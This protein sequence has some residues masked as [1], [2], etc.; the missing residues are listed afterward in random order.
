MKKTIL[1]VLSASVFAVLAAWAVSPQK[2]VFRGYDD[3]LRGKFDGVSL[4][5][6]AVLALAPR[7]DKIDGP[8]EDFYLSFLPASDGAAYLGTGH[9]GRIYR[10]SKEGKSE[11]FAQLPEMDVTCLALDA[12]GVLYAGTSPNGKVYKIT[13][14]G[15]AEVFFD[16]SERYIWSLAFAPDNGHL[17]A[18][19]GESGGIYEI[20]PEGEGRMIFKAPENHILC[21][22]FDRNRDILAGS[23]GA[24]LV[25]RISRTGK[26]AVIF[27]SGFEEVRSLALDLDGNIYAAA[28]GTSSRARKED[29]APVS[30]GRDADVAV[31]VSAVTVSGAP[32]PSPSPTQAPSS[33][34]P[35]PA[36]PSVREPGALF[37]IGPDGVAKKLW[38]SAEDMIYSLS[39]NESEKKIYF[40]TGP[41]GRLFVLDKDGKTTLVLQKSSEQIYG[42]EPVGVRTYILAD[43]PTQLS[44]LYPEKRLNG[45]YLSPVL[46]ARI[47]SSWGH[48][49]W[50]VE[51]PQGAT[52]QFQTRSGNSYEP[53]PG[54]SDWSPPY[55]KQDGEQ[56]LS[57]KGRYLQF[58]ALFKAI[59]GPAGPILSKL[60]VFY[61][62]TNV[63][64]EVT[65][66]E[67]LAPNEVFLKLSPDQDEVILGVERRSPDPAPKKDDTLRQIVSKKV[68][69]KG[70]QTIVWD[71]DDDNGD[72]LFYAISI[73][74]EGDKAWRVLEDRW[75]ETL[76]AF[77]T[78]NFPD[79]AYTLK[80]TA[81][82]L[83]SNPPDLE[84]KG[85]RTTTPL[86]IDNTPPVLRNVQV[87]GGG[88]ELAVSFLVE[89]GLS[90]VK[91]VRYL[92][93]PDEWRM[94]FPEDGICDSRQ[95]SF[96]FKAALPPGHD[97]LITIMVKDAA[98]N[99]LTFKQAF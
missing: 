55:S 37:R 89:D 97:G 27:E 30:A 31:T 90:A 99:V 96:K 75:T 7:E 72:S 78:L 92:I 19:V 58:K 22:K 1:A 87:V 77:N 45:E 93:R 8:T 42:L 70:N 69:R 82:D 65:R 20:L 21:L 46:D 5:S 15:K 28:G 61:L 62:Q 11:S 32:V 40:G 53:G 36:G 18:A 73:R 56:V 76:F 6:D 10:I 12:K 64:P 80:V 67:A 95:E 14:Q 91:D 51:L 71:A 35:A 85:E 4:T 47:V 17:L 57:P 13:G 88:S 81:S 84:K 38:S 23:G 33:K 26:G 68:E 39:W 50:A 54:W 44:V 24:G 59:A 49:S 66:L 79:G 94:V 34:A 41:K 52:L 98:G 83:P 9:T 16:P 63:A 48:I 86:T 43:N 25:Y 29:L 3:F 60:S 2:W 74:Q